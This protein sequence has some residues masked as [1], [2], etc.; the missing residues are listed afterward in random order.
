MPT[1]RR[2]KRIN[3]FAL[4]SIITRPTN[5]FIYFG[6]ANT[7]AVTPTVKQS[8]PKTATSQDRDWWKNLYNPILVKL[9]YRIT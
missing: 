6:Y 3:Y 4:S 8:A 5:G 1:V 7:S 9:P 2:L